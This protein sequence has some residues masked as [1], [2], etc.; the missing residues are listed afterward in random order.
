VATKPSKFQGIFQPDEETVTDEASTLTPVVVPV[1]EDEPAPS[2]LPVLE[3]RVAEQGSDSP[4]RTGRPATGKKSDPNYRQVTAYVRKDLYRNVTDSL[5]DESRGLD[6]R[7]KE[8]SE[9]IDELL[10]QWWQ[11]RSSG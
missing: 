4:R 6:T 11:G 5:Y 9:L 10:E 2:L 8:F 7:R 1:L 3:Q